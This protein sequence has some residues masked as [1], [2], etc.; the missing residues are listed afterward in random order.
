MFYF[1]IPLFCDT[2]MCEFKTSTENSVKP[3][4][5]HLHLNSCRI[6]YNNLKIFLSLT[7]EW[8]FVSI[9]Q[10]YFWILLWI[11][12]SKIP[13][14]TK[15]LERNES[16]FA[17][18]T[19]L[20]VFNLLPPPNHCGIEQHSTFPLATF[21]KNFTIACC[22]SWQYRLWSFNFRDEKP[23]MILSILKWCVPNDSLISFGKECSKPTKCGSIFT[24]QNFSK[25]VSSCALMSS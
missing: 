11:F 13:H 9:Q 5:L 1:E 18:S 4:F 16:Y 7:F 14:C 23:N 20:A 21:I 19:F 25:L 8:M 24:K 3:T 10:F 6:I 17:N 15:G 12:S 22:K 2:K